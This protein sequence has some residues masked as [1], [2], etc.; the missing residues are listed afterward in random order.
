M[1]YLPLIWASL[2]RRK[3]RT[4]L[5]LLSVVAA[6]LLF[7]LLDSVRSTFA[8]AGQGVRGE[9]RLYTISKV[10]GSELPMSL[11]AEIQRVPGVALATYGSSL[12]GTYQDPK[13]FVRIEALAENVLDL[14]PETQVSDADLLAYRSSRTGILVRKD[15]AHKLNWRPGSRIPL[16]TNILQKNG[17]TVWIFDM[18]GSYDLPEP[19]SVMPPAMIHWDF[20]DEARQSANGTVEWYNATVSDPGQVDAV[21]YAIDALS[22]NSPH[23]T[24]TQ[25][26]NA[27]FANMVR[28]FAD[29]G[30]IVGS[31]MGAVFFTLM[32]LTGNAM[33]QAVR[34]RIAEIAI[35]KTIG[36][37]SRGVL[38]LILGESV[39]LLLLGSTFGL[40]L[41]AIA[42]GVA[43]AEL[44]SALPMPIVA[45]DIW[46]RGLT[47]AVLIGLTV[48]AIPA[49]RGLQ[50]RIVDALSKR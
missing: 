29:I 15:W 19:K 8:Q 44:G 10:S 49:R 1:K 17:S 12:S 26:E 14:Y 2:F 35:L 46:L 22:T 31:I 6:F 21:A 13:N 25:S 47:L 30:L 27:F 4:I 33:A 20:F 28:E 7:G 16:Q 39:L 32:L 23:E 9:N 40:T 34:E 37:T 3:V 38:N 41:A 45:G 11:Y 50:L 18:V 5:T 43:R 42:I 48:G 24:Q 36:F